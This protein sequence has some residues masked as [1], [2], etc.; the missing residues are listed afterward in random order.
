MTY[1][2]RHPI[3]RSEQVA[4]FIYA[5]AGRKSTL[6]RAC[7]RRPTRNRRRVRRW[8]RSDRRG[9]F[10]FGKSATKSRAIGEIASVRQTKLGLSDAVGA[11]Y[12]A[13]RIALDPM[14]RLGRRTLV[15]RLRR[16]SL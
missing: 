5:I 8:N 9:L 3:L 16:A 6:A 11:L 15:V 1:P 13:A 4:Q 2:K 14:A 10:G 12:T 7:G